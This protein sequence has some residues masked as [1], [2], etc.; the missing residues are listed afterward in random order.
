V[1]FA[2]RR[3]PRPRHDRGLCTLVS[4]PVARQLEVLEL[5]GNPF[6]DEAALQLVTSPQL[7]G[8]RRLTVTRRGL[9]VDTRQQLAERFGA[10]LTLA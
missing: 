5:D 7:A 9:S 8:L 4:S 6:D 10:A 3:Q 2:S 1:S